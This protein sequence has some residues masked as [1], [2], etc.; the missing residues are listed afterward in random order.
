MT[1]VPGVGGQRRYC[2]DE[3]ALQLGPR[4]KPHVFLIRLPQ[5]CLDIDELVAFP[6]AS[7]IPLYTMVVIS[8]ELSTRCAPYTNYC[9]ME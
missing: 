3:G 4:K 2:E 9:K 8:V 7:P 1:D 6:G 5:L